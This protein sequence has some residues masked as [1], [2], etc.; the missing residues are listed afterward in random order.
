M[1]AVDSSSTAYK[2]NDDPGY[3]KFYNESR[4]QLI[5]ELETSILDFETT[6]EG[7]SDV[8]GKFPEVLGKWGWKLLKSPFMNPK[9]DYI[10]LTK[11][12]KSNETDISV[13]V[14][15]DYRIPENEGVREM[16]LLLTRGNLGS[17]Y[18]IGTLDKTV[19]FT[20]GSCIYLPDGTRKQ[21][22]DG[23]QSTFNSLGS[24]FT[25]YMENDETELDELNMIVRDLLKT[26]SLSELEGVREKFDILLYDYMGKET[27]LIGYGEAAFNSKLLNVIWLI[28]VYS[29]LEANKNWMIQLKDVLN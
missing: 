9:D 25:K 18:F 11:L 16:Q 1:F 27:G 4:I 19:G 8:S 6:H 17:L 13:D 29:E 28:S 14:L 15:L 20:S 10:H 2:L 3:L 21:I 7:R 5:N 26:N 12:A 24:K 23:D 22:V